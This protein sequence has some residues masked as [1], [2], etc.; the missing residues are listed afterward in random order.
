ME[1]ETTQILKYWVSFECNDELTK[2][3]RFKTDKTMAENRLRNDE[4]T[5]NRRGIKDGKPGMALAIFLLILVVLAIG[6]ILIFV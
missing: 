2:E 4:I 5:A 3:R 6:S 1:E